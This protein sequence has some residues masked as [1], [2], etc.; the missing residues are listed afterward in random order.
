[1]DDK[2][3]ELTLNIVNAVLQY[4]GTRPYA[5]VYQLIQGIQTQAS[6]QVENK[7]E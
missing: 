2:K 7:P 6:S 4:L 1:M 5:E 3:I